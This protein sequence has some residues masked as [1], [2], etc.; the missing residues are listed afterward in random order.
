MNLSLLPVSSEVGAMAQSLLSPFPFA[1]SGCAGAAVL[2]GLLC[3]PQIPLAQG[4][5][6]PGDGVA[7]TKPAGGRRWGWG[8]DLVV[9]LCPAGPPEVGTG[10]ERGLQRGLAWRFARFCTKP[11]CVW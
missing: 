2:L 4:W 10:Q 3:S 5:G 9:A 7:L 11:C 1:S 8:G 6:H